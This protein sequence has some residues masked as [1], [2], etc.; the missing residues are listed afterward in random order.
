M[1]ALGIVLIVFGVMAGASTASLNM[2]AEAKGAPQAERLG[3]AIGG[4]LCSLTL[5]IGGFF[6]ARSGDKKS[7]GKYRPPDTNK[8]DDPRVK[9]PWD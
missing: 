4:S 1:K 8:G 2:Q 6:L 7:S 9:N 5:V 3:Q